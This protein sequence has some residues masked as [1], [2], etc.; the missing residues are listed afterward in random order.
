MTNNT[1]NVS[2]GIQG[3]AVSLGGDAT[4]LSPTSIH[5]NPQT[6]EA[7]KTELSKAERQL[8][9]L[10]IPDEAKGKALQAITDA[11]ADPSPA[12]ITKAIEVLSEAESALTKVIGVGSGLTTIG[13][14]I[15]KLI[16]LV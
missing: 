13:L 6:I 3:G 10:P 15:A 7:L 5:Y 8:H 16:G 1:F 4:N 12:K 14:A 9:E 11:K 2:G